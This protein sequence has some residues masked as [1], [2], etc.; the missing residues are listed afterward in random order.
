MLPLSGLRLRKKISSCCCP[1][2]SPLTHSLL[3]YR[4]GKKREEHVKIFA[5]E[6]ADLRDLGRRAAAVRAN[7]LC[8]CTN[9]FYE[10]LQLLPGKA[11]NVISDTQTS[12]CEM[13]GS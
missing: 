7:A 3:T 1:A 4:Q 9:R 11:G 6:D 8:L 12:G 10:L 13:E 2:Q 5:T